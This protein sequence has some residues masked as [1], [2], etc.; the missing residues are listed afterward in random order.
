MDVCPL[1]FLISTRYVKK[2]TAL[3][4]WGLAELARYFLVTEMFTPAIL[5]Q[6]CNPQVRCVTVSL[7]QLT[8]APQIS[9]L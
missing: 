4:T 3:V 9:Q 7:C 1:Q 5:F 8:A 2:D 6:H